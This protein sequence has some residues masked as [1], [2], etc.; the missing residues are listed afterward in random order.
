MII[1]REIAP[2]VV[3]ADESLLHALQ[4]ISRN[5]ARMV[6]AVG[7]SG[8]LEGVMTD[9]DFRRWIVDTPDA[10]LQQP[11]RGVMNIHYVAAGTQDPPSHV[12]SLFNRKHAFVPLLDG[13]GRLEAIAFD[14]ADQLRLGDHVISRTGPTFVIAEIGNNH[15]GSLALAKRLVDLAVD[16]GADCV[17]FQLRDLDSLYGQA[18]SDDEAEDLGSQYVLDLLR[19]FQLRPEEYL[20]VFAHCRARG[21]LPLCTPWDLPSVER[22]DRWGIAGFKVASAD[23]TNHELLLAVART[24]KPMLVSTGMAAESDITT[25]V[26]LLRGVGANFALLHCNST[27]PAPFKDINLAYLGRLQQISGGVVGYSGHER[28][29]NV[30]VAAVA[31]GARIIE[32]HFTVDTTMEGNDHKVSLLPHEFK[33]MVEGI[34]EI[35]AAL[36][37]KQA[38]RIT[39]GE[40]MNR[41]VLGKSLA[42]RVAVKA[43]EMIR[44]DMVE[45]LAPGKG[46]AP[47]RRAELVGRRARRDLRP[48]QLFFPSDLEVEITACRDY[49]FRRQFG[50]PVRPHD[51]A[52]MHARGN[53]TLVEFHF[54][55]KDL[56]LPPTRFLQG[57]YPQ[58]LVVHAPEL[59][60]GDHVLDLCAADDEYRARSIREMQRVIDVTRACK[61]HF[62]T[63]LRPLIVTNMGGFSAHG[64]IDAAERA[65]G[66]ARLRDSLQRLDLEG[67]EVIAQTMPPFPWHFGGQRYHNLFVAAD[68]IVSFCADNQMRICLDISHSKLACNWLKCSFDQFVRAVAPFTAHL[69]VV[70][71]K[72]LDGEGLQI[73][74][75]EIDFAGLSRVLAETMPA[76]SFIPEVWQGHKDDGRGFWMALERLEQ[77]AL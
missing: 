37:S 60:A 68:D 61:P 14:Q 46:L 3:Q 23:L 75:G 13:H 72:G 52:A 32:K 29:I 49:R 66:Y 69:H 21:V 54:S 30:A 50:I 20:E 71:A 65:A 25:T 28:G 41:E 76:A 33:D 10:D 1:E 17:K 45:V 19:R 64:F 43:G 9:G 44:D 34:R 38:R 27:Y 31:L 7:E 42:A 18:A 24:R 11:V 59:F 35:E 48:G 53:F 8:V 62:P 77:V 40:L 15:N 2:F 55:H 6:L 67:I 74:E 70:D 26:R 51:F 39:Q 5:S 47:N 22:L 58:Q 56:E 63:T 12:A 36:G 4:K 16:A 73:G 57:T